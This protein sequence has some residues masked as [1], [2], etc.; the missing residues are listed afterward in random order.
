MRSSQSNKQF[1]LE[2][3][4]HCQRLAVRRRMESA[5]CGPPDDDLG[6]KRCSRPYVRRYR[7][8]AAFQKMAR[9]AA[10]GRVDEPE[11]K[12]PKKV[13]CTVRFK[14][15]FKRQVYFRISELFFWQAHQID[16]S[17]NCLSKCRNYRARNGSTH[18]H[19]VRL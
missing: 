14:F 9:P 13:I 15:G 6:S 11:K 5:V 19:G 12:D 10:I 18:T 3:F 1:R 4:K 2:R 8:V 16:N 7:C 17:T